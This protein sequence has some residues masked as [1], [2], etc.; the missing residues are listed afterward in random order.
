MP[1]KPLDRDVLHR[2]LWRHSRRGGLVEIHHQELADQLHVNRGTIGRTV[3]KMIE[4]GRMRKHAAE[5]G[6]IH[7]YAVVSPDVWVEKRAEDAPAPKGPRR[8]AWG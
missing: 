4:E 5:E 1:P 7:T 8:A 3:K 2:Y 6:N